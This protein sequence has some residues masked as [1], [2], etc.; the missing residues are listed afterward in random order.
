MTKKGLKYGW[1]IL[2]AAGLAD[3][4]SITANFTNET[5]ASKQPLSESVKKQ[6]KPFKTTALLTMPVSKGKGLSE[7]KRVT[8]GSADFTKLSE[9]LKAEKSPAK[10]QC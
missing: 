8:G 10:E 7:G 9:Q 5:A 1:I 4:G 3:A 2:L 6:P